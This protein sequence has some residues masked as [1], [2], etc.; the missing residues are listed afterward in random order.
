MAGSIYRLFQF[1][2]RL[3]Q[4][5]FYF[6]VYLIKG[7]VLYSLLPAVAALWATSRMVIWQQEDMEMKDF[8]KSHYDKYKQHRWTSFSVV[9]LNIIVL[10]ALFFINQSNHVISLAFVIVCIYLLVLINL[11]F[12]YMIYF[13][14]TQNH[15]MKN[16]FAL[17]FVTAIRRPF[18]SFIILVLLVSVFMLMVWNLVAFLAFGPCILGVCLNVIF[19]QLTNNE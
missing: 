17:A 3:I 4:M 15:T 19:Q 18:R 5:S 1:I 14:I 10:V 2:Y 11:N 16:S 13:L 8:F 9:I 6:W 7:L 12:I